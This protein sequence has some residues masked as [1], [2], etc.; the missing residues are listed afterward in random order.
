MTYIAIILMVLIVPM[1]MA[2]VPSD[3]KLENPKNPLVKVSTDKGDIYLEL[4]P[5]LAPKHVD[6][7][8]KLIKKGYYNG[9]DFP[10]CC[11]WI[12]YPRRMP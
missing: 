1:A 10:S 7:M 9:L 11:S 12:R 6:S 5:D 4:F 8:L 3:I 2:E